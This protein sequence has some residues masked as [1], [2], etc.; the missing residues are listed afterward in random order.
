MATQAV[1]SAAVEPATSMLE[2]RDTF[3]RMAKREIGL[4]DRDRQVQ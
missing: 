3:L 1:Q 4:D 2:R